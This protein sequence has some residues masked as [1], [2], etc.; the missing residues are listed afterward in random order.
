MVMLLILTFNLVRGIRNYELYVNLDQSNADH[1][2]LWLK[3]NTPAN[4]VYIAE[5]DYD[6]EGVMYYQNQPFYLPRESRFGTYAQ[7]T[8]ANESHLSLSQLLTLSDSF[9]RLGKV[10]YLIVQFDLENTVDTLLHSYDKHFEIDSQSYQEFNRKFEKV[11]DFHEFISTD[12]SFYVY[13][14]KKK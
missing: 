1:L 12:E 2:G 11:A 5:P 6:I 3:S 13:T 7:F 10:P 4:A 8:T 9:Q 14:K